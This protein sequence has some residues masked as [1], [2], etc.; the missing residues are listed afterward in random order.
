[1]NQNSPCP[2]VCRERHL[3][4]QRVQ[5]SGET[6]W[7]RIFSPEQAHISRMIHSHFLVLYSLLPFLHLIVICTRAV[8]FF[9]APM[10]CGSRVSIIHNECDALQSISSIPYFGHFRGLDWRNGSACQSGVI[11][12]FGRKDVGRNIAPQFGDQL[13]KSRLYTY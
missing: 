9:L 7:N 5:G 4:E 6:R 2:R 1:M 11:I 3:E 13:S 12:H 8:S 10:A